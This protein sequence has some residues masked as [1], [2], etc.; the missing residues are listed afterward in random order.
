MRRRGHLSNH[1]F[2]RPPTHNSNLIRMRRIARWLF[3]G[4]A[5]LSLLVFIVSATLWA[6]SYWAADGVLW[7]TLKYPGQPPTTSPVIDD[8]RIPEADFMTAWHSDSGYL[9][10]YSYRMTLADAGEAFAFTD[11]D[12]DLGFHYSKDKPAPVQ[13]PPLTPGQSSEFKS[14]RWQ[15]AGIGYSTDRFGLDSFYDFLIV[16]WAYFAAPSALLPLL[17]LRMILRKRKLA[18][19]ARQGLCRRCG[20]DMRATPLRCPECGEQA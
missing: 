14:T 9:Q 12:K 6:R 3:N 18:Y 16:P 1:V 7:H 4:L 10:I 8:S 2:V 11:F 15:H 5:T 19:R 17:R 13:L 20:Y